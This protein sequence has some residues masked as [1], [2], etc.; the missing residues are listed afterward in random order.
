MGVWD[1][2]NEKLLGPSSCTHSEHYTRWHC[3]MLKLA[4]D[5]SCVKKCHSDVDFN[6]NTARRT[7]VTNVFV[8][9]VFLS[10]F[11]FKNCVRNITQKK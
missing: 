10:T 9:T 6:A 1:Q 4:S 3:T 11:Y 2:C 7:T 5:F 8:H